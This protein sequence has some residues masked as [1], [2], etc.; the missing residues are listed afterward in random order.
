MYSNLCCTHSKSTQSV[1]CLINVPVFSL[2]ISYAIIYANTTFMF[3]KNTLIVRQFYTA[4]IHARTQ[5]EIGKIR[6]GIIC[7]AR[8]CWRLAFLLFNNFDTL[9]VMFC[10]G[11]VHSH[12][13]SLSFHLRLSMPS[14][15]FSRNLFVLLQ[16]NFVTYKKKL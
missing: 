7:L 11:T 9:Q 10:V 1:I 12:L 4:Q 3:D 2:H 16:P 15:E 6:G 13:R 14:T 8:Y 5:W